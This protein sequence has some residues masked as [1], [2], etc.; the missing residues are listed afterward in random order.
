MS[1]K[2]LI[3]EDDF[4]LADNIKALLQLKGYEVHHAPDG[5]AGV[6]AARKF[7]PDLILLDILIP[8]VD[9]F[10]VCR[11]LRSEEKTSHIHIIMVTGLGQ[12]GDV[13]K[14]L[15]CGAQDYLTKPFDS[16]RLLKK[17]QK[18]LPL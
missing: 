4:G 18:A 8:K 11:L 10:D 3:I 5:E 7:K 2:I 12:M 1:R 17:I 15:S 13:E 9:G 6:A 14:A 16:D